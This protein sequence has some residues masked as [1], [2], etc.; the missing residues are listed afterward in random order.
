MVV[1]EA[2]ILGIKTLNEI[3]IPNPALDSQLILSFVLEKDRL[4]L[5]TDRQAKLSKEQQT[6][7]SKLLALRCKHMPIAYITGQKEFYGLKFYVNPE[8]L[9]P[10][11][12]TEF[13]VEEVLQFIAS[14][15]TPRVAD[16][17][18]GSGAIGVSIAVNNKNAKVYASDISEACRQVTIKNAKIHDVDDRIFFIQG[19]LLVPFEKMGI[20]NFDVIVSNPPYIPSKE[21]KLLPEDVKQEPKL[22]LDGGLC[23]L[24]MYRRIILLAPKQLRPGGKIVFEIGWNQGEAVKALLKA[25]GFENIRVLKDYAGLDRIVS[26]RKVR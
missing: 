15:E 1:Q 16:I 20:G 7:Y 12:E 14:L 26:A 24:E 13:A 5:L 10:R 2:L 6:Q 3:D 18:C 25:S 21:I 4:A 19:D 8:V 23:G 9:V 11:P 17:C 22:A